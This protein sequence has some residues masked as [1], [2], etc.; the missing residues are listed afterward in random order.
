VPHQDDE[1]LGCC[2]LIKRNPKCDFIIKTVCG[3]TGPSEKY[4][5]LKGRCLDAIRCLETNIARRHFSNTYYS[6]GSYVYRDYTN[7]FISEK[8]IYE[9]LIKRCHGY[10]YNY[11]FTVSGED[12]H[13]E[14]KNLYHALMRVLR[15]IKY[16]GEVFT[17]FIDK[18]EAEKKHK[19]IYESFTIET[20][21]KELAFKKNL[22]DVFQTQSHFLPNLIKREDYWY[23]KFYKEEL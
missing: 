19:K 14:H 18:T 23:E 2:T 17:F 6:S 13:I 8:Q 12:K 3:N 4:P 22:I 20:T 7:E 10:A 9:E 16:K 11:I 21:K 1:I 5:Y 15:E